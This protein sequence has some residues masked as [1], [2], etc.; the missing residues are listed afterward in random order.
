MDVIHFLQTT[1]YEDP[2]FLMADMQKTTLEVD[3]AEVNGQAFL[4]RAAEIA[5]S[6][7]HNWTARFRK[8]NDLG[9]NGNDSATVGK[10]R[11]VGSF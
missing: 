10:G 5:A 6:G 7:M 3:F 1:E 9:A 8:N 11:A 2:E 4:K